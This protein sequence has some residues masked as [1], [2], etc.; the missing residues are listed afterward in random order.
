MELGL[1]VAGGTQAKLTAGEFK[2]RRLGLK[3]CGA[4]LP[5]TLII[6][7]KWIEYGVYGVPIIICP[8]PYLIYLRGTITLNRMSV[9]GAVQSRLAAKP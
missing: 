6:P 3:I 5:Q 1:T 8:K 4:L 2:V 9:S 7:L